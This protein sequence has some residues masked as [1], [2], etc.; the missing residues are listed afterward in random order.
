MGKIWKKKNL[1]EENVLSL[2]KLNNNSQATNYVL[3][4][5]INLS[6]S[7]PRLDIKSDLKESQSNSRTLK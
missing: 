5:Y 3:L 7:Y 1:N 2:R 6:S 4:W